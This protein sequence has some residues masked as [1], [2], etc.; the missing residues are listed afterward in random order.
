[1]H[2]Y[3]ILGMCSLSIVNDVM[4]LKIFFSFWFCMCVHMYIWTHVYVDTRGG[5]KKMLDSP[6]AVVTSSSELSQHRWWGPNLS[7]MKEEYTLLTA[8]SSLW[9]STILTLFKI[10]IKI[11]KSKKIL[12]NF[13]IKIIHFEVPIKFSQWSFAA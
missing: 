1:M 7:P 9:P 12:K 4:F 13:K 8:D 2:H 11:S 3:H 10:Y 5:Q 6:R